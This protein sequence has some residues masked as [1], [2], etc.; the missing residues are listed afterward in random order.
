MFFLLYYIAYLSIELRAYAN[1]IPLRLVNRA[2]DDKAAKNLLGESFKRQLKYDGGF[3][4]VTFICSK[5]DD[6]S[7]TEAVDTL[8]LNEEV[9]GLFNQQQYLEQEMDAVQEKIDELK[10]TQD[11]YRIAQADAA[12]DIETWEEL[13][14][15][16]DDGKPAYAPTMRNKRKKI[17]QKNARKRRQRDL[18]DSDDD[19]IASDEGSA[20]DDSVS[21]DDDIQPPQRP[22]TE[23]D[24]KIKLKDLRKAKKDAR[25][26]GQALTEQIKELRLQIRDSRSK[27]AAIKAEISHICIAGRNDY[28][29]CAIQQ[30]FA[31]GLRELDQENA[32]EENEDNFNPDEDIRDYEEVARSL[33][34]FCVSSRAYQQMSGRL[35]KDDAVPGFKVPEETEMPQL[36]A[37]CKKLTE[38]GRIQTART[39]LLSLCQQLT[40]F[41]LW[42]SDDGTGLKMTDDDKRQQIKYLDKRLNELEK[43]L[44]ESVRAC[45]NAMKT[46]MNDQIFDKYPDLINEAINAAPDTAQKWGAHRTDG[47]LRKWILFLHEKRY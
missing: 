19:F 13:Q 1:F 20:E 3:S 12:K 42:A 27:I 41:A 35:Q 33:P 30:D 28:S 29:K 22:L 14:E 2:V 32:A 5:T 40:T 8:E 44:E 39:F 43:G 6:I 37:H 11:I 34:V 36:Q 26:Q 16:L 47:G 38:A 21:G 15:R 45:L 18:D 4:S 31:A 24:I 10:E 9:E 46:D 17:Q 7:I 23:D 25:R